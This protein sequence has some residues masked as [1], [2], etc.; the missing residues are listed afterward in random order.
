MMITQSFL[1][2]LILINTAKLTH[3]SSAAFGTGNY[4][5]SDD[6]AAV[7]DP[8]P[9]TLPSEDKQYLM[10]MLVN[11]DGFS[12]VD[13]KNI[14][15]ELEKFYTG[16]KLSRGQL[17]RGPTSLID[18]AWHWHILNTR[19]YGKFLK[20]NFPGKFIHHTPHWTMFPEDEDDDRT[21]YDDLLEL[22]IKYLNRTIWFS[23][24][25]FK[26][27]ITW[28]HIAHDATD[29]DIGHDVTDEDNAGE[30]TS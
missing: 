15:I 22:D 28:L 26:P 10:E 6:I 12:E 9:V 30:H 2:L 14:L 19:M 17:K 29:G 25:E 13:A 24:V 20:N 11:S 18:S 7:Q 8:S 4:K 1:F 5:P 16:V 23:Q 3:S 27:S 21:T